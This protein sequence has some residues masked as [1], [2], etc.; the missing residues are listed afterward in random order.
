MDLV[1]QLLGRHLHQG[2]P[3]TC[4]LVNEFRA[5]GASDLGGSRLGNLALR[6][7]EHSGSDAHLFNEFGGR[8]T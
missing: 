6:V 2:N 8:Q 5:T 7:P 1:L 4:E 3:P